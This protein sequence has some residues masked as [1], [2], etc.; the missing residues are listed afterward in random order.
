M[1]KY[2][3]D[4][5]SGAIDI[6][7]SDSEQWYVGRERI[8]LVENVSIKVCLSQKDYNDIKNGNKIAVE[9]ATEWLRRSLVGN[10]KK[11]DLDDERMNETNSLDMMQN[12]SII[13]HTESILEMQVMVLILVKVLSAF[14]YEKLNYGTL[15]QDS[16]FLGIKNADFSNILMIVLLVEHVMSYTFGIYR[17]YELKHKGTPNKY[18]ITTAPC[19]S[20]LRYIEIFVDFVIFVIVFIHKFGLT[21]ESF[22]DM[23]FLNYW[24][25]ID[26]IIMFLTLPYTYMSKLMMITGE[27]TK[28]IFTLF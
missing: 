7:R 28:N 12:S 25:L 3:V 23:P 11:G 27:V 19:E 10:I 20:R 22:N 15:S 24:I 6:K 16:N 8:V 17:D 4:R 21:E 9:D 5:I 13:Y 26:C 2:I 18:G 1:M 14:F